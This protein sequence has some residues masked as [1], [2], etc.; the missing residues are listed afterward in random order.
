MN[1]QLKEHNVIERELWMF[2]R[3]VCL[4]LQGLYWSY[5]SISWTCD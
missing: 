2:K 4:L 5:Y 3:Y 1:W